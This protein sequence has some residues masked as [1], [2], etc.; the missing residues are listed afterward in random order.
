MQLQFL[1]FLEKSDQVKS[2]KD[3]PDY[4][5]DLYSKRTKKVIKKKLE[6]NKKK[7][8]RQNFITVWVKQQQTQYFS[9]KCKQPE[10]KIW[11]ISNGAKI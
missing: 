11:P 10:K 2:W 1:Y 4:N 9:V 6:G 8:T 3:M 5:G 7:S